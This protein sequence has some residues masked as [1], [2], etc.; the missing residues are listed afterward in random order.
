MRE[1]LI[2]YLLGELD[3]D[4]RREVRALLRDNPELQKE[5]SHLREC[6][7]AN[8]GDDDEP[9]PPGRLAERTAN[10]V[11]NSDDEEL[12][13]MA[14]GKQSFRAGGDPPTGVL[15]WSLADLTVAGGV[16]LAVSMLVFPALRDSRDGT[17][18]VACQNNQRGIWFL[19]AVYADNHHKFF[20]IVRPNE[21]VG[22]W[23]ARLVEAGADPKELETFLVCPASSV[24]ADIRDGRRV[25]LVPTRNQLVAM[26][27]DE[28][29]KATAP[30]S[31]CYGYRLAQKV[32][33]GY[34]YPHS[35]P[36][37]DLV[38]E[39]L[40][41]DINDDPSAP[42]KSNH[43][44]GVIQLI[45]QNGNLKSFSTKSSPV[46]C[47]DGDLYH[48]YLGIVDVGLGA[49]DIVLAPSNAW[50]LMD[51]GGQEK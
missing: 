51:L 18:L 35:G 22:M 10:R 16:M 1:Q 24:A 26:P 47:S 11:S 3:D 27:R 50:A 44:G 8:Q 29:A 21:N 25:I 13:R 40:F 17:R 41:G 9:L 7:S 45:G 14:A 5:L 30:L 38:F 19:D 48:N 20:P 34:V 15:G 36:S 33:D 12:E 23:V 6:L 4:E 42:M 32:G 37:K 2:R 49:D 46:W 43:R 39:P 28:L 31:M